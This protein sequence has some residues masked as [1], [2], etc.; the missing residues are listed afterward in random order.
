MARV[1]L[2]VH[3]TERLV[4]VDLLD[5]PK[6]GAAAGIRGFRQQFYDSQRLRTEVGRRDLLARKRKT[7]RRVDD[8]GRISGTLAEIACQHGCGGN[9][10]SQ[11]RGV[12]AGFRTLVARKEENLIALNGSADGAAILIALQRV[13]PSGEH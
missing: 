9:E 3:P 11:I 1:D 7:A 6:G 4:F 2:I 8:I 12:G 10:A 13:A 5:W